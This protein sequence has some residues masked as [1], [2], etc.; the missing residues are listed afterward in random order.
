MRTILGAVFGLLV[1][2]SGDSSAQTGASHQA[3][4]VVRSVR[5]TAPIVVDGLLN[6]EAWLRAPAATS[7]TQKDPEEGKPVS[8]ATE[9]RIAYDQDALYVAARMHDREPARIARQLS[10]RDQNAEADMFAV[11]LDP[12]HDHVTGAAFAV[13]AAGVQ[14]DATIYND[15]WTDDSWDAVWESAVKIDDTG[16]SAEMRIP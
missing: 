5:A 14:R 15:S 13:T 3:V 4:P 6:D 1:L 12:H 2:A 8:E 9:L 16:W 7:F 11:Y 10:R